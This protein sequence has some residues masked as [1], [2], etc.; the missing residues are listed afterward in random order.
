MK[1]L[2]VLMAAIFLMPISGCFLDV[3]QFHP[4]Q[5]EIVEGSSEKAI[6]AFSVNGIDG[7]IDETAKT[8]T[9]GLSFGTDLSALVASFTTTGASVKVGSA[10][11]TS[12][13]TANNFSSPAVYTVT[14]E[15]GTTQNYAVTVVELGR[16]QVFE[17]GADN[18]V[19]GVATYSQ[20]IF[21]RDL[22]TGAISLV[23]VGI[24]GNPAD[25]QEN[26]STG[27]L[28]ASITP[29]GRYVVFDSD[30]TNLVNLEFQGEHQ[31]YLRDLQSGVTT[32]V[33]KGY[34]GKMGDYCSK[35]PSISADGKYIVFSSSAS[36]IVKDTAVGGELRQIFLYETAT[37]NITL[38]SAGYE[39]GPSDDCATMPEISADGRYV[40]FYS[41]ATDIVEGVVDG[42]DH[43]YLRDLQSGTTSLVSVGYDGSTPGDSS[44]ETPAISADGRYVAFE[45]YATNLVEG[46]DGYGGYQIYLRDMQSGTT[47]LVSVSYDGTSP[48]DNYSYDPVISADGRYVFFDSTATNLVEGDNSGSF[49]Q[50]YVRDMG[51]GTTSKISVNGDGE[52]GDASSY[53]NDGD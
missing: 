20:Q 23:S 39:G 40:A 2:F 22:K 4:K 8:I 35:Q 11:Q 10:V 1:K 44:S 19:E 18:L 53:M 41:W 12:G 15:D 42:N 25:N 47:S 48:G 14:A 13:T 7:V 5:T 27:T 37:G 52:E 29:D 16:Y 34:D 50:V 36:N 31:V 43:V 9:V 51:T 38:V 28:R 32:L 30:A 45:S 26:C 49:N 17:S 24:D 33:S 6:T 21:L 46:F 3:D